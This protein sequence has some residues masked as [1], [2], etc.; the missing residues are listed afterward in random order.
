MIKKLL[1]TAAIVG[2]LIGLSFCLGICTYHPLLPKSQEFEDG[3]YVW[4]H[5]R[6]ITCGGPYGFDIW[7]GGEK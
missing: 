1:L 6:H 2:V 3:F 5:S 7:L 4:D